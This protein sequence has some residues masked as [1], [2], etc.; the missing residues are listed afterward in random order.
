MVTKAI[1]LQSSCE[2]FV[3]TLPSKAV[4]FPGTISVTFLDWF[5]YVAE[6]VLLL[7]LNQYVFLIILLMW[8]KLFVQS[9]LRIRD[10]AAPVSTS[11]HTVVPSRSTSTIISLEDW[12]HILYNESFSS[13]VGLLF[14]CCALLPFFL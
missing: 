14:N 4:P 1:L 10:I 12:V 7:S 3:T 2:Y 11:I 6:V 13:G 9:E 8:K 5:S